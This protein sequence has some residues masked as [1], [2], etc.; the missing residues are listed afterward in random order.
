V[1]DRS[2]TARTV[3]LLMLLAIAGAHGHEQSAQSEPHAHPK[4]GLATS[5]T[6]DAKHRLW[7]AAASGDHVV[8]S[9]SDDRGRN[10]STPVHVNAAP[11]RIA[12]DGDNRPKIAVGPD[13]TVYVSYTAHLAQ[14]Y[15]GNIRLSRSADGGRTFSTPITVND[16]R[17]PISHRFESLALDPSGKLHVVW[18]DKRDQAAAGKT[19]AGAA[20]YYASGTD[21]RL[22]GANRKLVDHGCECCRIALAIDGD[23]TPV[24]AWRHIFGQNTRDHALQRLDGHSDLIRVAQDNWQIDACPHQGPAIA[25]SGPGTYHVAWFTNSPTRQ[26]LFYAHSTDRRAFGAPMAFGDPESQ[27]GHPALLAHGRT[28]HLAW[29]EFD[30]TQ[31]RIRVMSSTDDGVGWSAASTLATAA[32]GSDLP[33]L[34]NDGDSVFLSWNTQRQGYRLIPLDAPGATL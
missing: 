2:I 28:I 6:F 9:Y 22:V 24:I 17:D 10:F 21:G 15:A 23:G 14:P 1:N 4:L 30:G 26:G 12:A 33:Q 32:G 5:V 29:K 27:A 13:G 34:V 11:E 18:I 16:N 31:G 19:Y 7:R 3:A 8:V 20:L 25:I